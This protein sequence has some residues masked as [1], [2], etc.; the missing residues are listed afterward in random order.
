LF[1]FMRFGV[2]VRKMGIVNIIG[3]GD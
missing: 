3:V 1:M 2:M